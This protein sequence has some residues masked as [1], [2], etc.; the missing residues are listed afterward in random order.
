MKPFPAPRRNS[1]SARVLLFGLLSLALAAPAV[2]L[3]GARPEMRGEGPGRGFLDQLDAVENVR[4]EGLALPEP[5]APPAE[6]APLGRP[7]AQRVV[8]GQAADGLLTTNLGDVDWDAARDDLAAAV[9]SALR[10]GPGEVQAGGRGTLHPGLD[11]VLLDARQI[12]AQGADEAMRAVQEHARIV[13]VLP[14]SALLVWVEAND[15]AALAGDP[16]VARTRAVEPYHKID[17]DLGALPRLSRKEAANPDLLATVTVVPGLDGPGFRHRLESLPGVSEVT[18]FATQGAGYQLRVNYRSVRGLARLDEV[19]FIAPVPEFLLSNAENVPT[20]QAGSAED[21][22][23]ARPFDDAGVDG[24]GIDTNGD[25]MRI[26]DGT[27]TVAPQ[28]VAIVDNGISADTPSFSQT[29]TQVRP[30]LMQFGPRHRKIQA[31]QVVADFG[32]GCD[33]QLSGGSTHGNVVASVIAAWPSFFGIYATRGGIGGPSEPRSMNL[34]GVARGSRIIMED[35]ATSAVCLIN[36][37]VEHG[38]NVSPGAL[39]DRLNLAICPASG[40]TGAC[41]GIT[42]GGNDTHL[43][44]LPFGVPNWSTDQFASTNGQY[45]QGAADVDTFL[46]NHRDFMVFAPVGNNGKLVDQHNMGRSSAIF[47][48]LFNGT[49]ADNNPNVPSGF[50][51]TSPATAKNVVSVGGSN[52][53]CFTLFG[54]DDCESAPSAYSSKGPATSRLRMAPIVVAPQFDLQGDGAPYTGAVA[55]FRSNDN[56]LLEPIDAQ[57]SEGNFGTSYAAGYMTGA[58]AIIRDYFAQGFYPTGS[59]STGDRVASVSGALVKAALVASAD[60]GE[61]LNNSGEDATTRNLRRTRALNLGVVGGI[62]VGIMGNGEQGFGRAVLTDVLPLSSWS[63]DFTLHP[64]TGNQPEWPSSG[65]LAFDAMVTGEPLLNN[66]NNTSK[67][68]DFRVLGNHTQTLPGGAIVLANAQLRIAL[69]WPDR[70][71]SAGSGGPLVNDLDLMV[72]SPG[73]DN[74]L[75]PADTKPDGSVCPG[76]AADDNQIF[77]GNNY[78]GGHNNAVTDQW[79]LARTSTSGAEVHDLYNPIEAVHLTSDR[80]ANHDSSDSQLFVGHW[81]VTVK[82]GAAGAVPGSLTI[83]GTGPA[84]EDANHNFRL[85]AGEDGVNGT[86]NGLLDL[87]GQD[88]ALVVSG[89]VI[90]AEAAPPAGPASYPASRVSWDAVRYNCASSAVLRILDSV[91]PADTL[92]SKANTTLQVLSAAGAVLDTESGIGFSAGSPFQT[93]SAGIPVRLAAPV[94]PGDGILEADSGST[95]VATY[96]PSGQR[97]VE[98]RARVDCQPDLVNAFFLGAGGHAVGDQVSVSA[99]CDSDAFLDAGETVVYGVALQNRSRGDDY[100]GVVATLTPSGPGASAIR[101]LDSPHAL[102]R[103]PAGLANGVFFHVFVD[104]IAAN[105][106]PV[107]SRVVDLTLTLDSTAHGA[108]LSR[109]SYTFH[110]ALNSDKEAFFYS[111]DHPGGGREVRD[112]NRNGVIDAPDVVDPYLGFIVPREDVLFS[113]LFSGSGAPAGHYTNELGEDL[114]LSGTFSGTERDVVPDGVVDRGILA[115]NAPS[116]ADK[117]PWSFDANNG[118]FNPFRHPDSIPSNNVSSNPVWEYKTSGLCGFQT[119]GGAG[120]FGIWHAGDGNPATPVAGATACD[121]YPMPSDP[122]TPAHVEIV[123]DV[124]ETPIVAKVNQLSDARGFPYAVEFQRLGLNENYQTIDGYAG[125]GI[126]VDNDIDSANAGSL[127]GEVMDVYYTRH[128][129]G[130]PTSTFRDS[131]F[132]W[133]GPGIFPGFPVNSFLPNQRTFGPFTNPNN[134]A[135][136]DGDETGFTGFTLNNNPGSSSPIPTAPPDFLPYPTPGTALAGVCDAGTAAGGPCAPANPSDPCVAGG[137]TCHAQDDTGAGPVRNFDTT[138]IGFEGG[139]ASTL[140]SLFDVENFMSAKPGKAGN[141]WQIGIGFFVIESASGFTDYGKSIDDVVFEWQEWHPQD[142][143]AMGHTPAC[144]RFGQPGQPAGGQCAT[145]TVDRA[146]FYECDGTFVVTVYDAKCVVVGAGAGVPL[147]GAC[148]SDADCGAGGQCSAARPSVDV[149]V[150]TDSD[151][152]P[153]VTNQY[154]IVAPGAK[155]FTLPAVAG[156]PGL[157]RGTIAMS[158]LVND[159]THLFVTPATDKRLTVYY[160]DPLCDGDRDGQAGEASFDNLDGDGIPTSG[161]AANCHGGAVAGCNDN[162]PQIYN[163]TQADADND[164]VGDPCDDCPAFADGPN[165]SPFPGFI[166]IDSNGD[167]VGDI[168]EFTDYDGTGATPGFGDGFPDNAGDNCPGVRNPNQ[169]DIDNDGRGDLCDTQKSYYPNGANAVGSSITPGTINNC[170]ATTHQCQLSGTCNY[171]AGHIAPPCQFTIDTGLNTLVGPCPA[172]AG[173][174]NT[175]THACSAGDVGHACA[176]DAD[177]S[178]P[179]LLNTNPSSGCVIAYT[180]PPTSVGRSCNVSADCYADNDRDGDG[181]VD[182]L[183]NC[184]LTANPAQTDSDG[185]HMGDACDPDCAGTTFSRICRGGGGAGTTTCTP[186]NT[187]CNNP[188]GYVNSC[189]WYIVNSGSCSTADDDK[190]A[191]GVPDPI[192]NCPTI[193]NPPV[194]AGSYIQA[195]ADRDGLGD[196]C[197]PVST[198]DDNRDGIPDDVAV[199]NATLACSALP[200]AKLTF[201]NA[202]YQDLDGDHDPF[203]DTGETG[204]VMVTLRNDGPSLSGVVLTLSSIDPDVACITQGTLPVAS[205]PSGATVT[206]GSLDPAQPGF[207]FTAS[208]SLQSAPFPSFAFVSLSLDVA[209]HEALGVA[210]PIKFDLFADV[211]IPPGAVQVPVLGPDGLAGT[212]DDGTVVENFDVDKNADL[213]FTVADTFLD[214]T[215][216]GV[217]RGYCSTAPQTTC[218]AD[219][220]CPLDGAS[221]PGVCY[222]GSYIQGTYG[223]NT[224]NH[225]SGVSCGGY[226]TLATNSQCELDPDFPMDWHFHCAPGSTQCPNNETLPGTGTPRSCISGIATPCSYNTPLN[227]RHSISGT[228]SLHMGAHFDPNDYTKGDTTHFRSLQ[229]FQSA[230][231][232]MAINPGAIPA[233]GGMMT[234]SFYQIADFARDSG[235]GNGGVGGGKQAGQCFDCGDVQV[236]VDQNPDPNI[237]NWG[238]WTK[239]VPFENVYDNK[240]VAWSAFSSYYCIFTPTDAGTAP[241]NPRGFHETMCFAQGGWANCGAQNGTVTT[242]VHRC[243]GPGVMDASGTGTWLN[244]KFNLTAYFGQRIRIRWIGSTWNFGSVRGSYYEIGAGFSDETFDDGWWIDDVILTGAIRSQV[245]PLPDTIPRTGSCPATACNPATGDAG[246]N[247]VLGITDLA[248]RVVDGSSF[249]P[250]AGQTLRISAA[251]SSLPGGCSGGVA[252]YEIRRNGA[253]IQDFSPKPF[254]LDAPDA[255]AH[256][257]A[258][259]RCSADHACTSVLGAARDVGV[260][261]GD[262]GDVALGAWG[263]PFNPGLGVSYDIASATTTLRWW[264]PGASPADVYRGLIGLGITKGTYAPPFWR[265]DTS[266]AAGSQAACLRNDVGGTPESAPPAGPGGTRGTTGPIGQADDPNPAIGVSVYYVVA[267]DAPGAGSTNAIGCA[268]PGLCSKAGFCDLGGSAGAPC[269]VNADCPGGTCL[270]PRAFCARSAGPAGAGGCGRHAVCLAGSGI[271][272]LCSDDSVC[273]GSLCQLPGSNVTTEGSICMNAAGPNEQVSPGGVTSECP[274]AGSATRLV[275]QATPAGLC[276]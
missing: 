12:Q 226:D 66:T 218:H 260:S 115:S 203:P 116:A 175:S 169:G 55:V 22:S 170:N 67:T 146:T 112:L 216:P 160:F 59:R 43:A 133:P 11:F 265:L 155:R 45:D 82:R 159:A 60:F 221:N 126:L 191:D 113:S 157:Y 27:D 14:G 243:T 250:T 102:G 58:G 33:A 209:S 248:G 78:D 25:G 232:N 32:T 71:S 231:I 122:A 106:L 237:D 30:G 228:Q 156:S 87:P 99:G 214:P 168:C 73:P 269:D 44:V 244:T 179:S 74:C 198:L 134:S 118:G 222:S 246:T 3:R 129:G 103:I 139:F 270:G 53:D 199:F 148:L 211:S 223:S 46:Y 147:G 1:R 16:F 184:P 47:P 23:F 79:S 183:D 142:E 173:T 18:P 272:H 110:H 135:G 200:L 236:Q 92:K 138:L 164:G 182:A 36:S 101:V 194:A 249:V 275:R 56:D 68:H 62:G 127:L 98:A 6:F 10:F 8:Q 161:F 245:T 274:P 57:L 225:V 20:V 108:R 94:V 189:Q 262:G 273:P 29:A 256:Y 229:G 76:N 89:P 195:D 21:S 186:S 212:A 149:A 131:N 190:D 124:L 215:A 136:L 41:T 120:K 35:A 128:S 252:E 264:L 123:M 125:G 19:R 2:L 276:P 240:F 241:P 7:R 24:G 224:A 39:I 109:Q 9:P 81:Q 247:A 185:D 95:I 105:A 48:D 34:D 227:G 206:L 158:T 197:D 266:G 220:D 70:P 180:S 178:L 181:I 49:A 219:A 271:G 50:Q 61:N 119:T 143:A 72:T 192:D 167:G 267:V 171:G 210:A 162:C 137:G 38:G 37:L 150:T 63:S 202:V 69:A 75:S 207:T 177:C 233:T 152:V 151:G 172:V 261:S 13:E 97:A 238:F 51:V 130:W 163:P 88:Y 145:V 201:V 84:G 213:V 255:S 52:A 196:A 91:G 28:I 242:N 100:D 15:L 132:Y 165:A 65:L 263:S 64:A 258:R 96:A 187:A 166:Q 104:P 86:T 40:G 235:E 251:G 174:C 234:M 230:P 193:P 254:V 5:V 253:V 111:T 176:V 239:L 268:N 153:V 144:S 217:Y 26:N 83:L 121:N 188:Y 17:L 205:I 259:V 85:D 114:D 204:R 4:L 80:N 117:I 257:T 141:R 31:I 107:A 42:G 140:H 208:N 90:L 77:D 93:V 54:Q 154:S